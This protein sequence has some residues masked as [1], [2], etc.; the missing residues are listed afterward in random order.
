MMKNLYW[1]V[2]LL[3]MCG[4]SNAQPVTDTIR[5]H[6]NDSTVYLVAYRF[7]TIASPNKIG[8]IHLHANETTALHAGYVY[9]QNKHATLLSLQPQPERFVYFNS[10]TGVYRFDPNRVFSLAGRKTNLAKLAAYH[11]RSEKVTA[12]FA[13]FVWQQVQRFKLV[14]ALHNNTDEKYSIK[15]YAAGGEEYANTKRYYINPEMDIDDFVLTTEE[16][17]FLYLKKQQISVVLQA[18]H[19]KDDGSLSIACARKGIPYINIEAQEDHFDEQL[20]IL[21]ALTPILQRYR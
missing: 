8:F 5:H 15:S 10:D 12:R 2:L 1:S 14:V 17:I 19:A 9:L 20:R 16:R 11:N 13:G 18:K 3:F 6:M 4:V 7:D 21:N